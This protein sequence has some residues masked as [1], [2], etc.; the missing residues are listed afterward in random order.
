MFTL[1]LFPTQEI[2]GNF[3]GNFP[4]KISELTTLPIDEPFLGRVDHQVDV[5][6]PRYAAVVTVRAQQCP[7]VHEVSN[8]QASEFGEQSG[9]QREVQRAE[10][11]VG[12]RRRELEVEVDNEASVN[13]DDDAYC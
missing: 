5:V 9:R 11:L 12:A 7:A 8:V 6:V 1:V 10:I 2:S 4:R 13:D 3:W